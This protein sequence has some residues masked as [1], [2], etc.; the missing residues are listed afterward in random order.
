[1][2]QFLNVSADMISGINFKVHNEQVAYYFT[3]A[4]SATLWLLKIQRHRF[5]D[6]GNKISSVISLLLRLH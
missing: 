5:V 6:E 2:W 4:L 3:L 1:M